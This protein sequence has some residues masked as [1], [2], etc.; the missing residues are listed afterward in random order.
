[1][2]NDVAKQL[3]GGPHTICDWKRKPEVRA[4]L[5]AVRQ[6]MLDSSRDHLR[7]LSKKAVSTL[8]DVLTNSDIDA[9][10]H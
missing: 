3:D 9:V 8:E 6:E 10:R 7:S 2:A 1:M 4:A 5:N